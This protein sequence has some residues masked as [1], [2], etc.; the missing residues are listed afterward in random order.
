MRI[1]IYPN[2]LHEVEGQN[3]HQLCDIFKYWVAKQTGK[4]QDFP[5]IF[6]R[7][8]FVAAP[9]E[10]DLCVL[11]ATCPGYVKLERLDVMWGFIE[12]VNQVGKA[13]IGFVTGDFKPHIPYK[14]VVIFSESL[15]RSRAKA[16]QFS[17]ASFA[18]PDFETYLGNPVQFRT[19]GTKPVIGFCGNAEVTIKDLLTDAI[20]LFSINARN[21]AGVSRWEPPPLFPARLFRKRILSRLARSALVQTQFILRNRYWGGATGRS[22]QLSLENS[23]RREFIGNLFGTDYNV[24]VRHG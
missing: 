9:E 12:Q 13:A 5:P 11:R 14:N 17:L 10:A 8:E 1:K 22:A 6:E 4:T 21:W 20:Q 15:W 2:T 23:V 24:C 7:F 19:K 16:P 18:T 3:K